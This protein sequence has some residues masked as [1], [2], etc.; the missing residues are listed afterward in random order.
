VGVHGFSMGSPAGE[1][2][3]D[4]DE[5]LHTVVLTRDFWIS[6]TEVT[7][8]EWTA[9]MGTNPSRF[10]GP[11]L[12]V[13][14]VSWF[15]AVAFCNARSVAAGFTPAYTI[16]GETVEWNRDAD[17]Y[18]LPTEAEWELACRSGT[19][20]AT[21][22]GDLTE[23][24]CGFDPVLASIAWYCGNA[25]PTTHEVA[26]LNPNS[27]GLHD[28]HGNVWE[29]CWDWYVADLG[30]GLAVDP[31]GPAGGAQRAIRG[32]SW[33]YFAREC[34]SASR[35]PYWPNSADDTVGFRVA[36]TIP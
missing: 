8:A 33:Y 13:E 27:A 11:S 5:I 4:T 36:R 21:S 18:R 20:T 24:A 29:W 28:M 32:G 30:E 16:S 1:V 6:P 26:T 14:R 35:G 12:P 7:Q 25:G 17:G 22:N 31:A 3:R 23:E 19:G 9:L 10:V 15:D 34:R 2:G